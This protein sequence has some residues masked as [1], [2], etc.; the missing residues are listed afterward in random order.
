MGRESKARYN[1]S[2]HASTHS[3]ETVKQAEFSHVQVNVRKKYFVASSILEALVKRTISIE[4]EKDTLE[5]R[6][7][8]VFFIKLTQSKGLLLNIDTIHKDRR[9]PAASNEY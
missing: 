8:L 2:T 6:S 7:S 3:R 9:I 4:L 1:C 5:L